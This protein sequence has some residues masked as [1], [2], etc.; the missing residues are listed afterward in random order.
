[1][2]W[3]VHPHRRRGSSLA[4]EV[5]LPFR[6][7]KTVFVLLFV[8]FAAF[9]GRATCHVI[10]VSGS[11]S[12]T[13]ADWNNAYDGIPM[14]LTRGDV[15]YLADGEYGNYTFDDA[16]SGTQLVTVKKAQTYDHC[17]DTGWSA[18]TMGAA[19]AVFSTHPQFTVLADYFVLDGN[20]TQTTPGCGADPGALVSGSPANPKDCG[21][22]LDNRGCSGSCSGVL[23][24]GGSHTTYK[25]IEI[26]GSGSNADDQIEMWGVVGLA[27]PTTFTH[28]YGH[29]A[30]CV[31]F[32]YG[33]NAREVSFSYFWG[34]EVN[35]AA[36]G[37]HGQYS[38]YGN[39]DSN[40]SEHDNVYRDITGTAVWT[41]AWPAGTHTNWKY[42][43]N[44]V[45]NSSPA[46][47]WSPYLSDGV[48][49]C[50]N[51]GVNCTGFTVAQNTF[52]NLTGSSGINN[53]S[54]GSYTVQNNI[55]YGSN[56]PSFLVGTGGSFT[57]DHNS[58]LHSGTCSAGTAN[59]TN[60]SAADPFV[61][62]T[63]GNFNL[64]SESSDWNNR[65]ALGVPYTTD[66]NGV[67]RTSDRGVY[68][69]L[70][71]AQPP[72]SPTS[73]TATVH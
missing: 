67:P 6:L 9:P 66:P 26:V 29:N 28:L 2:R 71:V 61:G 68:E 57:Q 65:V 39:N 58:C 34:T 64:A 59:V 3:C 36:G 4:V 49:A 70:S 54:S 73:L 56:A 55:Y 47:A 19:Q 60:G 52:A 72:N 10:T 13:G 12:K 1:M 51:S 21:I 17:T 40:G 7:V 16:V 8:Y 63:T 50:I 62:W 46:V 53:E 22:K 20:G 11:G 48:L 44:V 5:K 18:G 30:G 25:Y 43:N 24:P 15:Y 27:G 32:Q 45:Y 69:S 23:G 31:Y 14:T 37:C 35:G 33:G 42:Y 38:F 41:F